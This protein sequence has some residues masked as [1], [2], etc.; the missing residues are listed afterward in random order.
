MFMT[1]I[2]LLTTPL[3]S[4]LVT[5]N[6][7]VGTADAMDIRHHPQLGPFRIYESNKLDEATLEYITYIEG[8]TPDDE[9]R[10][11]QIHHLDDDIESIAYEEYNEQN[12][13]PRQQQ[14]GLYRE[15]DQRERERHT[16]RQQRRKIGLPERY[17]GTKEEL[18]R[19][20][21]A[22]LFITVHGRRQRL[23]EKRLRTGTSKPST[24]QI[25]TSLP[26]Q[27][28]PRLTEIQVRERRLSGLTVEDL[29]KMIRAA[30]DERLADRQRGHYSIPTSLLQLY[31]DRI[32]ELEE[33]KK[34][35]DPLLAKSLLC[36]EHIR[37]QE[38]AHLAEVLARRQAAAD[39]AE[40][41][42][43]E[44]QAANRE[45]LERQAAMSMT[46]T[47]QVAHAQV[48][49]EPPLIGAVQGAQA[50]PAQTV[51]SSAT[52]SSTSTSHNTDNSRATRATDRMLRDEQQ[53]EE[54]EQNYWDDVI[55]IHYTMFNDEIEEEELL[56][57]GVLYW[58]TIDNIKNLKTRA[59]SGRDPEASKQYDEYLAENEKL[60]IN[61]REEEEKSRGAIEELEDFQ[62]AKQD[63]NKDAVREIIYEYARG[64][65][66]RKARV[67]DEKI[68]EDNKKKQAWLQ[69]ELEA[70]EARE[71]TAASTSATSTERTGDRKPTP[72]RPVRQ[73][74]IPP[75][76]LQAQATTIPAT[77]NQI[78][79]VPGL[80]PRLRL[81]AENFKN[82]P[83]QKEDS[84]YAK[85]LF[86]EIRQR[87]Y[88]S[89]HPT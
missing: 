29:K 33:K 63:R 74:P 35:V 83:G 3:C 24:V 81:N 37:Q 6:S 27:P 16:R 53:A 64:A 23:D 19:L 72:P 75:S 89:Q 12:R 76:Q 71:A 52:G 77:P 46:P 17:A 41:E 65:R 66:E 5:N 58:M 11:Q 70:Q 80:S 38:A 7:T 56:C 45:E 42:H 1:C 82:T 48:L 20:R 15:R 73:A 40:R 54:D 88:I 21:N 86:E 51:N 26:F 2:L 30:E 22:L 43:Q 9:R 78:P 34:G 28:P 60:D 79:E 39:K 47:E 69:E 31:R 4:H 62:R 68:K 50:S 84:Y 36:E 25:P 32:T 85:K 44:R 10:R 49:P 61:M 59:Q 18:G 8:D 57:E 67:R 14:D 87:S 55:E 13:G